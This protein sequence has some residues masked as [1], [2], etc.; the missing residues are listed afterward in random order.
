MR[1]RKYRLASAVVAIAAFLLLAVTLLVRRGVIDALLMIVIVAGL[2]CMYR[3]RCYARAVLL[4]APR[5]SPL[6]RRYPDREP[7]RSALAAGRRD[8]TGAGGASAVR[9][10]G[11]RDRRV[12]NRT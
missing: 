4:Y 1:F 5:R 6:H 10:G 3:L 12:P 9:S 11:G 7:V 8:V 2:V